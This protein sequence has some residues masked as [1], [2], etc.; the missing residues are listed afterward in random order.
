MDQ[1]SC[2]IIFVGGIFDRCWNR[3]EYFLN[4]FYLIRYA[5]SKTTSRDRL[6]I[7]VALRIISL[8]AG[9]QGQYLL[10]D[11]I[12]GLAMPFDQII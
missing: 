1:R 5:L 4:H 8:L 2:K 10:P 7:P 3:L 6:E 9:K 11:A 12:R